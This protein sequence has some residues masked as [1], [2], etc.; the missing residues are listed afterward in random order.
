[1]PR[2]FTRETRRVAIDDVP[3]FPA[4]AVRGRCPVGTH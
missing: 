1:M 2:P 4:R 3:G